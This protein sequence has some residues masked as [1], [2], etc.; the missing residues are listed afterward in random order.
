[1]LQQLICNTLGLVLVLTLMASPVYAGLRINPTTGD[2]DQAGDSSS[3]GII[4]DTAY[5]ISWNGVTDVGA[6]KNAL[7]DKIEALSG[8][9]EVNTASNTGSLG[10]GLFKQKTV[11]DLEFYK[12]ASAN[13]AITA[14]LSGTDYFLL[15]F[16]V[17][18]V[19]H[20]SLSGYVAAEH[21]DWTI[22]Q[23]ATNI[24]TGNYPE[25]D[26][27]SLLT[28]DTDNIKDTHIDWG[29]G[30]SQV[31]AVDI[32][33]ADGGGI[34]TGTE[35][36]TALQEN[37][38]AIDLNTSKVT[39][40]WQVDGSETQLII[41]DEI[42]MQTF[43]IINVVD[44]TNA[45]DATTKEYVDV[46]VQ[47]LNMDYF[48]DNA[49][50][51][52][53]DP[54][55]VTT[56]TMADMETGAA[57]TTVT[58]ASFDAGD[59]QLAFAF[60]T[61]TGLPFSVLTNG[62]YDGHLHLEKTN[63]GAKTVT[64]YWTL[65]KYE[66]DTTE[67]ILCTSE[68]SAAITSEVAFDLHAVPAANLQFLSTDRLIFKIYVNITGGG[69]QA[70]LVSHQEGTKNSHVE[71]R[72][73]SDT[74]SNIYVRQD[75]TKPMTA[76]WDIGNFDITLKNLTGDGTV[77][78]A[79][80]NATGLTVS[81]IVITDG[82]KNLVS[83]PVAT[84]PSLAEL[85]YI[86]GL[87]S[88]LQD[89]LNLLAPL[90][91]PA[92]TTKITTGPLIEN[93]A[94]EDLVIRTNS[95]VVQLVLDSGGNVGLGT[96]SPNALL[97]ITGSASGSVG[98][99]SSGILHVSSE[100]TSQ[101]SNSIITGH[102]YFNTNT[103]LWYLGSMT[104]EDDNI[105]FINRQNADMYFYTNNTLKMAIAAGGNVGIGPDT[106]PDYLLDVQGTLEGGTITEGGNAVSNDTQIE[107]VVEPLIDTLAN[108][109]SIQSLTVTLADAGTDAFFGWDDAGGVAY[110]NLTAAEA[111][112]IIGG[113]ATDL[114]GSGNVAWGN[115]A[116]GELADN[117]VDSDDFVHEDW[118]EVTNATGSVVVDATHSGSAHHS[119]TVD[120]NSPKLYYW[121]AAATLPLQPIAAL[122]TGA[123]DGVGPIAKD[124]DTN[125]EILAVA[126]DATGDEFRAVTF[127]IPSDVSSASN[128]T[129]TFKGYATTAAAQDVA[130]IFAH[131]CVA[132]GE[133][134]DGDVT[135]EAL[136]ITLTNTQDAKDNITKSDETATQL[137][138]VAGDSCFAYIGR[139]GD[140]STDDGLTTDFNLTDFSIEIPRA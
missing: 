139:D 121:P 106:T 59:N 32:P 7:Y 64:A 17:G 136:T 110:E 74:L 115:I 89:Q 5:G 56:Y 38:T 92:F 94:A 53:F 35:V 111:M 101:F 131:Y 126:W 43:K 50:L 67:T 77:K 83:A 49:A 62:V 13:N 19:D 132:D 46:A 40:K 16:N 140:H 127:E 39:S 33:I 112:T 103:Q 76:D 42:D 34:I 52:G 120:T 68:T 41:A 104:T 113:A 63:G 18:N 78:G 90:D 45:Q 80:L 20:D 102:N 11:A 137:G 98:G 57:A 65:T 61:A 128:V 129:I 27:L 118:G 81:E 88:A 72:V 30:A 4:D 82:S 37:R 84:Y 25:S 95:N 97:E 75:G 1:M 12:I 117:T 130:L 138:W 123:S 44:P 47:G 23:G 2:L 107:A 55:T 48:L 8:V 108:L 29:V 70:E 125:L 71:V 10:V 93:L 114:D 21:I 105:G 122:T 87:S 86:K 134:W 51:G 79:T 28:A 54:F 58:S 6:S 36:E 9:G 60:G 69:A 99:F 135:E 24:H 91:S 96:A 14:A 116:A 26:P 22:D 119:A 66:S 3:S 109:T 15:T 133:N 124:T 85:A 31:S 100:G 73:D